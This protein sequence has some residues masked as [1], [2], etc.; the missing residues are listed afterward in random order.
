MGFLSRLFGWSKGPEKPAQFRSAGASQSTASSAANNKKTEQTGNP[1]FTNA[2]AHWGKMLDG[3]LSTNK[4]FVGGY[5]ANQSIDAMEKR[6]HM[7]NS[8]MLL[9]TINETLSAS[10]GKKVLSSYA[11]ALYECD[12]EYASTLC[13]E[14]LCE[15]GIYNLSG[16][17]IDKSKRY[18]VML[19]VVPTSMEYIA[20]L[21]NVLMKEGYEDL[22]YYSQTDPASVTTQR[23]LDYQ[24]L[25]RSSFKMEMD[26]QNKPRQHDT[27]AIWWPSEHEPKFSES[28]VKLGVE[29]Y[30]GL[31]DD[32]HSY[33]LGKLSAAFGLTKEDNRT[34]LPEYDEVTIEGPGGV[35]IVVSLS[36]AGGI[37]FHFP[38]IPKYARY[39]D[40]FIRAYQRLCSSLRSQIDEGNFPKDDYGQGSSID[41]FLQLV[42]L[43]V[44]A[45]HD[46]LPI[47]RIGH[48]DLKMEKWRFN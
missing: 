2:P 45:N 15:G 24:F 46:N 4:S 17:V 33:V 43:R 13:I 32:Y 39:R 25:N 19:F 11:D 47:G 18:A 21:K 26:K 3:F 16:V 1:L 38:A 31:M 10:L 36:R 5:E 20:E 41:W 29:S 37:H 27:F 35:Q 8:L 12:E 48:A 23:Q 28:F 6:M 22:I 9:G 14:Q 7:V 40:N 30:L 34:M 44:A 42:R